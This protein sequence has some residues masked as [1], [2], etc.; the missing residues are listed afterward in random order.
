MIVN[1]VLLIFFILYSAA[2]ENAAKSKLTLDKP[3]QT[4]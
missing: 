3:V 4:W 1:I 2:I